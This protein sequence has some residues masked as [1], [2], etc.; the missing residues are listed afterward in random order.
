MFG[1]QPTQRLRAQD[2]DRE[3]KFG[4]SEHGIGKSKVTCT[5]S[6]RDTDGLNNYKRGI[7]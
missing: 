7:M 4:P 3:D 6:R 5:I 1:A 2:S